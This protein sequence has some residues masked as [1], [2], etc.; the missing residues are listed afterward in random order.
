MFA[1]ARRLLLVSLKVPPT[2][3]GTRIVPGRDTGRIENGQGG[4]RARLTMLRCLALL[5]VL[6][7]SGALAG[8]TKSQFR[9]GLT[10]TGETASQAASARETAPSRSAAPLR[11]VGRVGRNYVSTIAFRM[12]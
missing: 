10:I 4:L 1:M 7:P 12:Y 9:V 2:S 5:L 8:Q 6:C 3:R 11:T